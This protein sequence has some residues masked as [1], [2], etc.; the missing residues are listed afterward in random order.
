MKPIFLIFA[1][2]LS[3]GACALEEEPF[4]I[5]DVSGA[6]VKEA[7]DII[8]GE[9]GEVVLSNTPSRTK[10]TKGYME[11]NIYT[12]P[13]ASDIFHPLV[14]MFAR[15]MNKKFSQN[16]CE[17]LEKYPNALIGTVYVEY[18]TVLFYKRGDDLQTL[19]EFQESTEC[20]PG[21]EKYFQERFSSPR[22]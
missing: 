6:D 15:A 18:H 21:L 20:R 10:I 9:I 5:S 14:I 4:G 13:V 1:L 19:L 2:A 7:R 12:W 11:V 22:K 3:F 16:V 17:Y 8:I